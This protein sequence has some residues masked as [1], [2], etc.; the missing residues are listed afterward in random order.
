MAVL[1]TLMLTGTWLRRQRGVRQKYFSSVVRQDGKPRDPEFTFPCVQSQ[2]KQGQQRR[3]IFHQPTFQADQHAP[4]SHLFP[5]VTHIATRA[6]C[7][8][9]GTATT[10]FQ[11]L[12]A[13]ALSCRTT[14]RDVSC[15]AAHVLSNIKQSAETRVS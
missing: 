12:P 1:F 3:L 7:R 8:L 5:R 15:H 9:P 13:R 4:A 2:G 14:H 11:S 6:S 10:S